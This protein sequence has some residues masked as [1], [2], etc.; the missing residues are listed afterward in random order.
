[1]RVPR[2][3][4]PQIRGWRVTQQQVIAGL[5]LAGLL[6]GVLFRV[7]A[8]EQRVYWHDEAY[9]SM[10]SAGYTA[11]EVT[12][13]LFI[14]APIALAEV[15]TFQHWK[16]NSTLGDTLHSLIQED[17]QHPP[18][19]FVLLRGWMRTVGE[20]VVAV[21][22]LAVIFGILAIPA[23]Y[24]LA[25]EV[26][27]WGAP[28]PGILWPRF[29]AGVAALWVALSPVEVQF[30]RINRQ[31][32]LL[33]LLIIVSSWLLLRALRRSGSPDAPSTGWLD[34]AAYGVVSALGLYTQLFFGLVIV[35]Q[36]GFGLGQ[37]RRRSLDRSQ[38]LGWL[39]AAAIALLLYAPW[40][41]VLATRWNAAM[42]I[43]A[44]T[45]GFRPWDIWQQ[46]AVSLSALFLDLDFGA[47]LPLRLG[48]RLPVLIV[49]A[50][51]ALRVARLAPP[52][53][54]DFLGWLAV[55]PFLVMLL[56]DWVSDRS[57]TSVARY[58]LIWDPGWQLLVAFGLTWVPRRR[59][60]DRPRWALWQVGA[61]A[62]LMSG[63]IVSNGVSARSPVWWSVDVSRTNDQAIA[64][65]NQRDQPVVISDRGP[66]YT[67]F[68]NLLALSWDWKSE[69]QLILTLSPP[70]LPDLR[71]LPAPREVLA[72][73]PT[74]DLATLLEQQGTLTPDRPEAGVWAWTPPD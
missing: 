26:C 72:F 43:T 8:L 68:G 38:I 24:A 49:M 21:R 34:W 7:V 63:T 25:L 51:A 47:T 5:M 37:W 6:L 17:P 60:G 66:D 19:Y 18:L 30:S 9:S 74:A 12:D 36:V 70:A 3:R 67:N 29:T 53:V 56:V 54:R 69:T 71:S 35:A 15:Q 10:R 31:Y 42:N 33:I 61:I 57:Y 59:W 62:L 22:S 13:T 65:V 50:I 32:S 39:G 11:A 52:A 73:R 27:T 55:G 2:W 64:A 48:W 1:M 16:P 40:L 41:A 45:G 44:W 46:S 20:S 28:L 58:L 4:S 23:M 14:Q